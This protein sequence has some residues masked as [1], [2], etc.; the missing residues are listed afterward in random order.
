MLY[1]LCKCHFFSAYIRKVISIGICRYRYRCWHL[2][3]IGTVKIVFKS[4]FCSVNCVKN[5][6]AAYCNCVCCYFIFFCFRC[7]NIRV[8]V[9]A[10][11]ACRCYTVPG[12]ISYIRNCN[13]NIFRIVIASACYCSYS[14]TIYKF[15]C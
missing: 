13:N 7:I 5:H 8:A 10:D 1:R 12:I 4:Y 11:N 6:V 14:V 15:C 3:L 9:P 2:A